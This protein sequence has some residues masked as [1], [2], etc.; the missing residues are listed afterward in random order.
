[1]AYGYLLGTL[2]GQSDIL[3]STWNEEILLGVFLGGTRSTGVAE[4]EHKFLHSY[5]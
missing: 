4:A 1:M 2:K 3:W 5:Q